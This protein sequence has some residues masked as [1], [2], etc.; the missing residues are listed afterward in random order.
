MGRR[1]YSRLTLSEKAT[2]CRPIGRE[3]LSC[4]FRRNRLKCGPPHTPMS[5]A[6][7]RAARF[8]GSP[9]STFER[10]VLKRQGMPDQRPVATAVRAVR[11]RYAALDALPESLLELFG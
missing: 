6:V 5:A 10:P 3:A 8:V 11:F 4:S 9:R 2:M 7:R 1:G